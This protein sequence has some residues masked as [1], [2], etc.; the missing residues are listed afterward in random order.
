[1]SRTRLLLAAAC[2]S[3]G[4][5]VLADVVDSA[6]NGFTLKTTLTIQASPADVYRRLLRV[7]DW[8]DSAH[9][10]SGDSHN[11]TIEEKAGG[12]FCEKTAGQSAV[13]HME[14]VRFDP[15]KTLV[16]TGGLGPL[17]S[18]GVAAAM[19]I[20]ISAVEG[21]TKMEV[22]YA[23]GG[24]FAGGL[25]TLAVPVDSVFKGQFVR[26][27]NSFELAKPGERPAAAGSHGSTRSGRT[28]GVS[29]STTRPATAGKRPRR[30]WS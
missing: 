11:L 6:A 4:S 7:G 25:N 8:W 13:K 29:A 2:L 28:A 10:Y 12:C 26:L 18:M 30:S 17:Q 9:T 15:G 14:V 20:Q 16:M 5:P 21:G 24:Y 23:V 19:T 27:K 22:T 3:L 1:M